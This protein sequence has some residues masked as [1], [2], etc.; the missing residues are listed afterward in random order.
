MSA[1]APIRAAALPLVPLVCLVSIAFTASNAVPGSRADRAASSIGV[2]DLKPNACSALTLAGI[3]TGT[4][5]VNDGA[6]NHLVLGSAAVDTMRGNGGND[7]LVGG[8]SNDS[9]RGDAGTDVC[10]GGLG[11]DTFHSTCETQIQ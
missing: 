5:I 2:N 1:W 11:V 3:T 7:C 6:G 4:G 8:G 9:L 10:I